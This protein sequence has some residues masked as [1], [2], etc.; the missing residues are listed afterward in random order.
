[1]LDYR[2]TLCKGVEFKHI[3]KVISQCFPDL[4][5]KVIILR[6]TISKRLCLT[7]RE[8][9]NSN[10]EDAKNLIKQFVLIIMLKN[11]VERHN[12]ELTV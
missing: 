6:S 8:N 10:K 2:V 7:L 12:I 3:E 5:E 1:M 11:Y 4:P 9:R